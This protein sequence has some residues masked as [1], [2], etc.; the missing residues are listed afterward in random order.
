MSLTVA[1]D[2]VILFGVVLTTWSG[3][4]TG[5]ARM[6][7]STLA[8]VAGIFLAA[9]GRAPLAEAISQLL[10]DADEVLM[11]LLILV[12]ASWI[13]LGLLSWLIGNLLRGVLRTIRLGLVDDLFGAAL[14]LL[15][16]LLIFSLLLF[17]LQAL[18]SVSGL[19]APVAE[20]AQA[21]QESQA[22]GLL[23][24]TIYPLLWSLAGASLPS[25]L[26]QILRP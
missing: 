2:A 26:Q 18:A 24:D 5:A 7:V 14:G 21:S 25:E 10:P 17:L 9:Q 15:Q 19:P 11:S 23:R 12:G 20:V 22:A 16:G 8:A 3:W 1:A 4:R 13:F 6:I